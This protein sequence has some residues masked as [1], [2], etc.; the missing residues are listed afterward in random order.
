VGLG[1]LLA[2]TLATLSLAR[3]SLAGGP[4]LSYRKPT[5]WQS[6]MTL[7]VT[8]RTGGSEWR[9]TIPYKGNA[10][11]LGD[12]DRFTTLAAVYSGLANSDLVLR[13]ALRGTHIRSG[14]LFAQQAVTPITG[15]ALPYINL[16]GIAT[17][18]K[19]AVDLAKRGS[20]A[21]QRY[22]SQ[23]QNST[24]IPASSRVSVQVIS[25]P[26]PATVAVG[27][28]KTLPIAAFLGT[29][30]LVLGLAFILENLRPAI[31]PARV[32]GIQPRVEAERRSA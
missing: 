32:A 8:Q 17:S 19:D 30:I 7:Q 15:G 4:H 12:V 1:L 26:Q 5:T 13:L 28:K 29:M 11:E 9:S 3:P 22:I 14:K 21:L 18:S 23:Q 10:P 2:L 24:H 25:P 16:A 31:R 6:Y 20:Q 27:R